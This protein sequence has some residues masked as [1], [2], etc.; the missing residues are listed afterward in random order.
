VIIRQAKLASLGELIS[1]IAHEIQNPLNFVT[2]FSELSM[3]L[4]DELNT[5]K[6]LSD[7]K[8]SQI[9]GH[10]HGKRQRL[11]KACSNIIVMNVATWSKVMSIQFAKKPCGC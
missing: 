4:I 9:S 3:E 5:I 10:H 8:L 6:S 2:N 7:D 11:L 1:D